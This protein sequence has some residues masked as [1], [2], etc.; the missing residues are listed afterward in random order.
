MNT[1]QFTINEWDLL[2]AYV[3]IQ[4]KERDKVITLARFIEQ[5]RIDAV[6]ATVRAEAAEK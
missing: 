2:M 5:Q 1:E 6:E 4:Q 3:G